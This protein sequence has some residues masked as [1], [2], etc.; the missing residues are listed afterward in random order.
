MRMLAA[1]FRR[2]RRAR[3]IVLLLL[4]ALAGAG[5]WYIGLDLAHSIGVGAA[6]L[7]VGLVL[8]AVSDLDDAT[9]ERSPAAGHEGG[10]QDIVRLSWALNS[11]RDWVGDGAQRRARDIARRR[12]GRLGLDLDDPE[13]GPAI[14][15][16]VG[17]EGYAI[18]RPWRTRQASIAALSRTLH[19]LERLDAR[20]PR[21]TSPDTPDTPDREKTHDAR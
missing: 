5:I 2:P 4:A 1:L 9:W 12:L 21:P 14:E 18:L 17:L 11:R 7:G 19:A 10:R 15:S 3:T 6:V 13:H 16:L 8:T 20:P